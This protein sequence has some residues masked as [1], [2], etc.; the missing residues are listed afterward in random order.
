MKFLH[1]ADWHVGR[2]LNGWSLLEEQEW[3][4]AQIVDLA[5]RE[6]V[7]GVLIAGDLYDRAVPPVEAIR[8]FNKTLAQLVLE[9]GI[10]VYAISGNHDGAERLHFGRDFFQS[11]GLHL[12]TRLEEAFSPIELDDCQIFLLPFID[13]IDARIY[14]KEEADKEIT[15][16]G[17]ALAYIVEDMKAQFNPDK[18]QVLVTHFA[19][20]KKEG[21]ESEEA[22]RQLMLSETTNTIGGLNTVTSDLFKDFDYVALGHIHTHL[23]SPSDRIKYSGSPVVFNVKEAKREE[24][25]GVYLIELDAGGALEQTFYPLE[26][27]RPIKVL[28]APFETLLSA[29]YYGQQPCHQAWFSFSIELESRKELEGINVRARLEEIYGKDIVEITFKTKGDSTLEHQNLTTGLAHLEALSPQDVVGDFYQAA[30]GGQT[31]SQT[32]EGLVEAIF[33]QLERS[34][35]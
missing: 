5:V 13:P 35:Q 33:A 9:Q 30:T 27:K 24:A 3:A 8:L 29:D 4:L 22:L 26:V 19:V 28:E 34:K 31:L 6:Q 7:D 12:S 21:K 11:Q 18:A 14:Y 17:Q 16:I 15:S 32:Q 25:K 1:T 23:A 10:P 20:S 2:T